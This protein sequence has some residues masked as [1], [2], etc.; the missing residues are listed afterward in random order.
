MEEKDRV[1]KKYEGYYQLMKKYLNE[2]QQLKDMKKKPKQRKEDDF[3]TQI[4][5]P[6]VKAQDL[7]ALLKQKNKNILELYK[8]SLL[9]KDIRVE[10]PLFKKFDKTG[11]QS[12]SSN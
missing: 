9:A 3:P 1:S 5:L 10:K 11:F 12:G 8:N 7:K 4:V 6:N 2:T